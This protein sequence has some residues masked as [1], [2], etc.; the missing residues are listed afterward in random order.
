MHELKTNREAA[1][2]KSTKAKWHRGWWSPGG[3]IMAVVGLVKKSM[4]SPESRS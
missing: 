3:V 4:G 1:R 2:L